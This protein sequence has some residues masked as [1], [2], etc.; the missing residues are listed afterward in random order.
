M[1]QARLIGTRSDPPADE[2]FSYQVP[3]KM[4]GNGDSMSSAVSKKTP[5]DAPL[6][7]ILSYRKS[8]S[9]RGTWRYLS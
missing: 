8:Y 2:R 9:S 6:D 5:S 3:F 7:S 1:R 4:T